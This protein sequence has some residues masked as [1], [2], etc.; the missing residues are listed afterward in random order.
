MSGG[1]IPVERVPAMQEALLQL[2]WMA[3]KLLKRSFKN[4]THSTDS[5]MI[6]KIFRWISLYTIF[7]MC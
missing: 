3:L 6:K 4:I 5:N 7:E 1:F 2:Q